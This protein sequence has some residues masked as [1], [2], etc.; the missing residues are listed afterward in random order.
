MGIWFIIIINYDYKLEECMDM[1][2][3]KQKKQLI[4]GAI[5][6]YKLA[7]PTRVSNG[8]IVA[9]DQQ[10]SY[11]NES[12]V[13]ISSLIHYIAKE[14]LKVPD[15]E[16]KVYTGLFKPQGCGGVSHTINRIYGEIIDASIEQFNYNLNLSQKFSPYEAC[17]SYYVDMKQT[18]PMS[19]QGIKEEIEMYHMFILPENHKQSNIDKS[20]TS[21]IEKMKRSLMK[22]LK[23]G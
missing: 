5:R 18:I 19:V 16:N 9:R 14:E 2:T 11:L 10:S 3:N 15:E 7:L 17:E 12:C 6:A 23:K 21:L 13:N 4:E 1:L 8:D 22:V 20:S